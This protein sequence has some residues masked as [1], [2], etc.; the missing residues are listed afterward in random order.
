MR[1]RRLA[2]MHRDILRC[3]CPHE[4]NIHGVVLHH[5]AGGDVT[6]HAP[7]DHVLVDFANVEV[8]GFCTPCWAEIDPW[9]LDKEQYRYDLE[10]WT[11]RAK[12]FQKKRRAINAFLSGLG[13][14]YHD[15]LPIEAVR[16]MM[17][18]EGLVIGTQ[19]GPTMRSATQD[20]EQ[21]R[22]RYEV[23]D[24]DPTGHELVVSW[25]QM[26]SGRYEFTAYIS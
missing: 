18:W 3:Q 10:E 22:Q 15:T 16:E 13:K 5:C 14:Q 20:G 9:D 19:S 6:C 4:F 11:M 26:Q 8:L 21:V 1:Y 25:Y 24:D 12:D 23:W 17:R 7:V 2:L